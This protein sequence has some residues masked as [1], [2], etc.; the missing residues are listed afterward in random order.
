MK[1]RRPTDAAYR[2]GAS[3]RQPSMCQRFFVEN[4]L[5]FGRVDQPTLLLWAA[6]DRSHRAGA[7]RGLAEH[8]VRV[9]VREVDGVGHHLELED[10]PRIC[11]EIRNDVR[12]LDR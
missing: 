5:D 11:G 6:K 2:R 3:N 12:R 10:P 4:S 8:A 1:F 7:H 9:E